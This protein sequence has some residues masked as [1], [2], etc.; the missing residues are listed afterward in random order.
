MCFSNRFAGQ[1]G[2]PE[3]PGK[4]GSDCWINVDQ[5]PRSNDTN[6]FELHLHLLHTGVN[7]DKTVTLLPMCLVTLRDNI[8]DHSVV[9]PLSSFLTLVLS[10]N[11]KYVL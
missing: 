8:A 6:K 9:Q 7:Q 2:F 4:L 3:G 10:D 11:G 1:N 5:N